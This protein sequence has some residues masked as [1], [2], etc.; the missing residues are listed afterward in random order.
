MP[1]T[2]KLINVTCPECSKPLLAIHV[3][4]KGAKTESF[5]A[6]FRLLPVRLGM[7]PRAIAMCPQ[8]GA[9]SEFDAT[10]LPFKHDGK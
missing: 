5:G 7:D 1:K 10:Y 2:L 6:A 9:E 4:K 3:H 8:C